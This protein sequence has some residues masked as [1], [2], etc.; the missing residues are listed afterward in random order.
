M[1]Q[2]YARMRIVRGNIIHLY[3]QVISL[4]FMQ[5]INRISNAGA[6]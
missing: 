3:G 2:S 1:W 4:P 5:N 6:I